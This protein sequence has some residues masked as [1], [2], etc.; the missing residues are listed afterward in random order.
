MKSF[1]SSLKIAVKK[2]GVLKILWALALSP[3]AYATLFAYCTLVM[4]IN[5][6]MQAFKET[7]NECS[8]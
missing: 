7:W 4:L 8:K 6:D 2:H 1:F 5:L 3:L